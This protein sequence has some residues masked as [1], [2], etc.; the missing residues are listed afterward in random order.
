MIGKSGLQLVLLLSCFSALPAVAQYYV[1]VPGGCSQTQTALP[2]NPVSA[3]CK[4]S[5]E[6][7]V[8]DAGR[9]DIY[10]FLY[11]TPSTVPF[12]CQV[13]STKHQV[14]AGALSGA[15]GMTASGQIH[16]SNTNQDVF[17]RTSYINCDG[18]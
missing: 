13:G 11:A 18:S 3:S 4:A 14:T 8:I 7:R 6:C 2:G 12:A 10:H 9:V 17:F 5:A 1:T 16:S 15:A